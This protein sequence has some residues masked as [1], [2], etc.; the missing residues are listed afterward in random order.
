MICQ[1]ILEH[2]CFKGLLHIFTYRPTQIYLD[3]RYILSQ[4][5]LHLMVDCIPLSQEIRH[6][7]CPK[8]VPQ[9]RCSQHLA[10]TRVILDTRHGQNGIHHPEV[11]HRVHRHGHV[12]LGQDLRQEQNVNTFY[13]RS[14]S[15]M[16]ILRTKHYI[17]NLAH[18][19][20]EHDIPVND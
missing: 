11:H 2:S 9:C 6:V 8:D 1:Y 16:M 3:F 7:V 20:I 5:Y 4:A 14:I 15:A 19:E 18:F 10:R 13:V 12:V 17:L